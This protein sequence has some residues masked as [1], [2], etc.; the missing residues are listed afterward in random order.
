MRR[1]KKENMWN[2]VQ[3]FSIR[4]FSFGVTSALLGTFFLANASMVQAEV[5]SGTDS[6]LHTTKPE[7][8][9]GTGKP[10]ENVQPAVATEDKKV[11]TNVVAEETAKESKETER[12]SKEQVNDVTAPKVDKSTLSQAIDT[13]SELLNQVNLKKVSRTS[14]LEYEGV[15]SKAR[16]VFQ[17]DAATQIEVDSQVVKVNSAISIAKSFPKVKA[18]TGETVAPK[19]GNDETLV[20]PK[21]ETEIKHSLETVKEDLQKYVKKSEITTDKPNV[22]AAGEILENISKQLENTTLTSKELTTLLEQAK[23]VRNSLV[24]EELRATSGTRDS[25]NGLNMGNGTGFRAT[26]TDEG[27]V[28]GALINVKEFISEAQG[29]G[30]TTDGNRNRTI[31]KTFMT[32]KYSEESGRKFITYDVYFQN[33]GKAL[34][35]TSANALWFYPPRDILYSDG[36][37]PKG[38]IYEAY[39]ERYRNNVG[40][41]TLS[42]NPNNFSKV[43]GTYYVPL[44][45][46]VLEDSSSQGLWGESYSFFQFGGGPTR[47]DQRQQMLKKLEN[48]GELNKII[49]QSDGSYPRASYSHL[50]NISKNVNYAYKYHVKIRLRDNVTVE[51]AKRAGVIAA[52]SKAG[53]ATTATAAYVYAATGTR[54]VSTP[55][56]KIDPIK[57]LTVTKT[58]GDN[59]GDPI[60]PVSSGYVRHKNG[61]EFPGGMRW[62]WANN[63]SP[64]TAQAGVFKYTSI[65]TYQDGSKSND[66]N[67]GSDGTVTLNVKPI[68]PTITANDVVHKK[69]LTNQTITVNVGTG[70]KE[71]STVNLYDGNKIIGTGKTTGT[72]A[73]VTVAGALTG[74]PITAET[75]VNNNGTVKSDRSNPVTPTDAPDKQAPTVKMTN[76]TDGN[77]EEVLT[78]NESSSPVT[79]IYR[80]ATLNVP[81]KMYDN[82]PKGK[83]N[84]KYES[85][86]PKGVNFNN[87]N[88][89]SKTGAVE[90]KPG[91]ATVTGKVDADAP[92][93]KHTATFKVSDDQGGNVDSGNNATVKF[94]TEVVDLTFQKGKG[95]VNQDGK[96]VVKTA[97]GTSYTDSHDFITTTDGKDVGDQFFAG[98]MK[99]RFIDSNGTTTGK[100][101]LNTPGKHTVKAAA[102]FPENYAGTNGVDKVTNST[103]GKDN[104]ILNRSFLYKTIEFQVKPTAP[105]VT[106]ET[107][108][109]VTVTPVNEK[110]VNTF[111]FTYNEPN[112][113][114]RKIT[115]TKTGSGWTLNNAPDDGVTIDKVTGKVTIKDRAI[116]DSNPVIAKSE[117]SD[118]VESDPSTVN[119]KV[120]EKEPPKFVFD[121]NNTTV[122][123]GFRTVYVT[124]T[125]SNNFKLGTVTDNSKK[126]IES[127]LSSKDNNLNDLDY[128]LS[129]DGKLLKTNN[130]PEMTAPKDIMITGTLDKTNKSDRGNQWTNGKEIVTRYYVATDAA[131]NEL[132]KQDNVASNPTR[133]VFK[134]L[135]QAEKYVPQV[136]TQLLDKDVTGKGATISDAEFNAM[137]SKLDLNFTA[138]R[139]EVKING[140]TKDLELTMKDRGEIK[141]KPDGTY[142]VGATI[143]YPDLSTEDIE[144]PLSKSDTSA[145][146]A[147]MDGL[148]LTNDINTTAKF[149][150]F[151]GATFNPTIRVSDDKSHVT[152]LS[153]S[154]V[155]N[156]TKI[157]KSGNW[158]KDGADVKVELG[159]GA[160]TNTATLGEHEGSVVVKDALNNTN[161]YKFKYTV[162][163][164]EVKETPKTVPLN[165]QLGDSHYN[166]KVVDTPNADGSDKYYP[167][168]MSFK[169]KKGTSEVVNET[170]LAKPGVITDYKALVKFPNGEGF[171]KSIDGKDV[172]IYAPATVER[173]VTFHVKPTAPTITPLEKGDVTVTPVSEE[174]VNTLNFTYKHPNNS[175]ITVTATKTG[176]K[177]SLTSGAPADGVTINPDT[178]VVTIKD[179][180]IKDVTEITAKSVTT[181][182]VESDPATG[183]SKAG[184]KEPPKFEF[185]PN[186]VETKVE[187]NGEQVVYVTPTEDTNLTIGKVTDDSNKLTE[188]RIALGQTYNIGLGEGLSYN[189]AVRKS[190]VE[191]DA[192]RNITISGKLGEYRTGTTK[193]TDDVNVTRYV[194]AKDAAT[195]ELNTQTNDATNKT[196]VIF[197]V[198]TQATKYEPQIT[199]Q[200]INV[201]ITATNAKITPEDFNSMKSNLT[202]T[203]TRGTVKVDNSTNGLSITMKDEGAIKQKTDGTYY[204]GATITYPDHSTDEIQIPVTKADANV[205]SATMDG[206]LLTDDLNTTANFVVFKGA[207]FNP[208][209]NV[210]D[211]KNKITKLKVTGLP[212]GTEIEKTGTWNSGTNIKIEEEAN[213]STDTSTLGE[214]V[215]TVEVTDSTNN[216]G[217]YKFKYKVVDVEVRNSPETVELGTKLVD[218]ANPNN[219]KDSHDYV[220]LVDGLNSDGT[221]KDADDKYYPAGMHFKWSKNHTEVTDTTEFNKPGVVTD[222]KALVKFPSGAGYYTTNI[223]G[224]AVKVYTPASVEK[225]VTFHV[226]P[227]KPTFNQDAVSSTTRTISGTLGGFNSDDR[228][229][230]VHLNDKD[231]TVLSS[232]KGQV[233]INGD[234]W[235]AT[236]P[237]GVNLRQSEN[238]NGETAQPTAITVVNKVGD[239]EVSTRSDEK[240]VKMGEY[241]PS[242]T[243]AGSKHIDVTVPHDAKRVELRFHNSADTDTTTNSIVLVRD[244]N[245]GN[246]KVDPSTPT[247][248]TNA[249]GFVD[250]ITN[251]V[252]EAN[253]AENKVSITLKESD[254]N[255]KLLIKEETALGDNTA[256]YTSGLGLRV[257]YKPESG[258]D[259]TPAGNWKVISVTNDAPVVT[260]KNATEGTQEN[261]KVYIAGTSLTAELLKELVTVSDTE[262]D[263]TTDKPFGTGKVNILS[264]LPENPTAGVYAVTLQPVDSQGKAGNQVTVHVV[265]KEEKPAA[266]TISQWQNGNVKV[267]P[268]T[269]NGGDKV[270]IPLTDGTVTLVKKDTGWEI[271]TPKEGVVFHNGSLEIPKELVGNNVTAKAT[272]GTNGSAVDSDDATY[273]P[274]S[275]TVTKKDVEKE[276]DS[277]L[278]R[279]D[280]SGT[281][282]V[283][284]VTD[285]T[286]TKDFTT[287]K[288]TSVV[289]KSPLPNV[290][291]DSK[292]TIPVTITYEDGSTETTDVIVK[293]KPQAPTV[294]PKENGTVEITPILTGEGTT[295]I[296]YTGEDNTPQT[297]TVTKTGDGTWTSSDPTIAVDANGKVTIPADKVKDGS[298]V[299]A[300]VTSKTTDLTSQSSTE[301]AGKP[302][303]VKFGEP[304]K[305]IENK[306]YT[307]SIVVTPNKD[308]SKITAPT[309]NGLTVNSE[310]KVTGTPKITDWDGIEDNRDVTIKVTVT[311]EG[312][313]P[314]TKDIVVNVL[315]DTDGDGDPDNTDSDDDNDGIPD[316]QDKNPKVADDLTGTVTPPAPVREKAAITPV[317]VVTSN[318]PDS[319][320]TQENPEPV[321]GLSVNGNGELT[322]TPTVDNWDKDEE[323][324]QINIPVKITKEKDGKTGKETEEIKVD[325]PVTILRDTDGDGTPDKED[326]DDDNDG[327]PD[328]EEKKNG[329]DPKTPTTQTPT[330]GISR[331]EN[332]DVIVTPTKPGG[333]TYPPGTT[334]TIPGNDNNPI[335]VT[336]G[337]DGSGTVPNDKLPKTD[338]PGTGTV[339]EPNKAPSKP[340]EVT[341]PARKPSTIELEQDP[342]TGD[343]T[344]TPKKPDGTTYPPGTTVEIPGKN[345]T[346]IVVTIEEGGKGKVSNNDLPEDK[347]P[348]TGKITEKGKD[349]EDVKVETPKRIDPTLPETDAPTEIAITRKEN[350]DAIVTPK[351]PGGGTYPPETK[352][353]IP[354]EDGKTIEVTIGNDG[355]GTVPNDSL[356]K[357]AKPGTGTVTEPNKK[358]SQ[359]VNV[360]TP[361]RK[362]P[363]V[364]LEQNPKTGDVTVTPK[365]PGGETYPPGTVVEIPGKDGNPIR[366]EIGQN[367]KGT[368]PNSELP[369]GKTPGNAKITE[370][371]KPV[372]EV[373][374]ETPAR[375]TP[376]VELQQDPDTGEVTVTPKKPDGTK[377]PT[378][379]KVEI[380]GKNGTPIVVT[381]GEDGKGKVP[382][383]DLPDGN[384]SGPG[385]IT[386]PGTGKIPEKV[387]VETPAR[388]TPA[389]VLD[390]EPNTGDVTVTPKK[391]DGTTYPPGTKVEIPGK[392]GTPIVVTTGPDGKVIIPNKDLPDGEIPGTG[393]ITPPGKPS[394]ELEVKTPKKLDPNASQ[395]E[396]PGKIEITRKPNGDA[397]V[398]P[399][400]PDGTTYPPG[401]KVVIPGDHNTPIEVTIGDN[402]SG[403]VPND[404]LPKGDLP[405]K[406]I[407]TEPNKRPSQPVDVTT[408]ARKT[409]TVELEQDPSTGDVTVTPKKPD[410]SIYA[411]GTKVEIPGKNGTPI[412]VIIGEDG[413]GKVPNKDLPEG[414]VPGTGKIIEPGKPDENVNVTTP[415]RKTPTVKLD[416]DPDSGDVT[417]TPKKPDGTTYPPGTKVEIPGKDKNNPIVVIIGKDGKG[418]VPNKDLPDREVPGNAKITE[419]GKDPVEVPVVT[420]PSRK[421]PTLEL[422]QNP[423]TGDVTVTPKKPDG[424]T[425]PPGTKVEIPGKNG[426]TITVIIGEDG[427]GKVP[428]SELPDGKVPG[429]AKITEPGKPTEEVPVVTTPARK[430]P[431]PEVDRNPNVPQTEQPIKIEITRKPNGDAV[432]TPKK[433]DGST[434]PP[435]TRVLIPGDNNTP[436]E[437][438]IGENGSGEVPNDKL[439]KG[440]LPG[441]GI[442]TE[443]NKRPSNPVDVTTPARK[444]PTSELE[445]NPKTSDKS[446]T[447]KDN[448]T[449]AQ[450]TP[451][452]TGEPVQQNQDTNQNILPNTGTADGLG[453]FSAA[454]ASI[455]SGLGLV[456]FGKKEDEESENN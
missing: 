259:A 254:N 98:G 374:V 370:P 320:I 247:G 423:S 123:N 26:T 151:K 79:R 442:V 237:D 157:E 334:V 12:A 392:D 345:G 441:K 298:P 194:V 158:S 357:D 189:E 170:R 235:T 137:K 31:T 32:A 36:S 124:P 17:N 105:T 41:G 388:L 311:H 116:K 155:S 309:V 165:T 297:V 225:D 27:R 291:P 245:G 230:E 145:P 211:D 115:A 6:A 248:V 342:K 363:T 134:V 48:N 171:R 9:I 244:E 338:K 33:D 121:E 375:K 420:T 448:Q 76:P 396:Q 119:S 39:Y 402:G 418:K 57:G 300:Q 424:T 270:T 343:V 294:T 54:L 456:V 143:K 150:V 372:E 454:A 89:L 160:A 330:I 201:D 120:G 67:T 243:V 301:T 265:V 382:N 24:N 302:L 100:V 405:G 253:K 277:P 183:E 207:K 175:N 289:E 84:L 77:R 337:N 50:L 192:P 445:Q 304:E 66:A 318:K 197:K 355:S 196:R 350:G 19:I 430:T 273:T 366:V 404:K 88:T 400:K 414:D 101:T 25:R 114:S 303:E 393:K 290:T 261:P 130:G 352:V 408:P 222:Y 344:V 367:G 10:N 141:K 191:L 128:G 391:P 30:S 93:G 268:S 401:T 49:R 144:I 234:T 321:N 349:P 135:T 82:N 288:I 136:G 450:E 22:T 272:K 47:N 354:G 419:P 102:Y 208:T 403:E 203:S 447:S 5:E 21:T 46:G 432:V 341:T 417:V 425:Y 328:D 249:N 95:E 149:V 204:V 13:L 314:V 383:K 279:G 335:E 415:S 282:G 2:Q 161:T 358:P 409:P 398:T 113:S 154:G 426:N 305:A 327:I 199:T 269:N 198:L 315:R 236:L 224:K 421:T 359:P 293:V 389:L 188:V 156:G 166:V 260:L 438:I 257:D 360:T 274:Q 73:R 164:V 169:W 212:N 431:T 40:S 286:E 177:W 285:G 195:N 255:K 181:D 275:H 178:G 64:S 142:Y 94:R 251:S 220:K 377:Y 179:R 276:A 271:E 111:S 213:T 258:Q 126:L 87:G 153:V 190:N 453:I 131:G 159:N 86:L 280:L 250:A 317:T 356:P 385:T 427:K 167:A 252:N 104:E 433:P 210:R 240:V 202:F 146:T 440:D 61:G 386:E 339:T 168:G 20:T 238:K 70:V 45:N 14:M 412:V 107:N 72:T 407:V 214:H 264:G 263:R 246:W 62:S 133:V 18:N 216:T 53:V 15:L 56:A 336:I 139:G 449:P 378:G 112:N 325:V 313:T 218:T 96:L 306:E 205:P 439:P 381:I 106:P 180:A 184:D 185:T 296:T 228:V 413:K 226:A 436:I 147:T 323:E 340:V 333:G 267:T 287:A 83:V 444:T 71:G 16:E 209:F 384:I 435:G 4:K 118:H 443:P 362:T 284:G 38:P 232:K 43:G 241:S 262:D 422:D 446:E 99:F 7:E 368:V 148:T 373:K 416:Q 176:N 90:A 174:N 227:P 406:G 326:A 295:T 283:T 163:D 1:N 97:K 455:L 103:P 380:P 59:A 91:T 437:V 278:L 8:N 332:G 399:K 371:N 35:G 152:N 23:T 361:A 74:N 281:T 316:E 239:T 242:A 28:E 129:Y 397:V 55:D 231:N 132:R 85:G 172:R 308:N 140:K 411:P 394:I 387:T 206:M 348:G 395:T 376:T 429:V 60:N 34:A 42:H 138:T 434:Y 108:G 58:V 162:V 186:G 173:P 346:P 410:G 256:N 29:E 292:H 63:N 233:T 117:T 219:G 229:V 319:K 322:G 390:Q 65:A 364:E 353:E 78:N 200:P 331:K 379:T 127:R 223:D 347:T 80:G 266:P 182:R 193:W 329:T 187:A 310:G 109:D 324:R 44:R 428:N 51:E 3:R 68:K 69:G 451:S 37:Y 122:E 351:K 217:T 81:L 52:T 11:D 452:T 365:K 215:G 110:N 369:D 307:S 125:E 299:T 221:K 312:D 92:L 75:T